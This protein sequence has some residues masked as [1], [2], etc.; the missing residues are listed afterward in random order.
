MVI[1]Q[2]ILVFVLGLGLGVFYFAGLWLT[3]KR[4]ARADFSA[5]LFS[6]S[7]LLRTGLTLAGFYLLMLG[8]WQRL[9]VALVGFIVARML[10]TRIIA[11]PQRGGLSRQL[12]KEVDYET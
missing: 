12:A 8:S 10:L 1:A 11:L 4:L 7:F 6:V 2:I 9:L 5:L 3:V